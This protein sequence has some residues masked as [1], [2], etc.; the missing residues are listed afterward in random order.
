V[1]FAH[2]CLIEGRGHRRHV[3]HPQYGVVM[4]NR[5]EVMAQRLAAHGD[6]VFDQLRRLAPS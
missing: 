1:E 5:L 6:A 4:I 3:A 2:R